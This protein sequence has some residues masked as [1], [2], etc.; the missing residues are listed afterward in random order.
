MP[1]D[2]CSNCVFWYFIKTININQNHSG[3]IC[4]TELINIDSVLN[5]FT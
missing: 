3:S 4:N 5:L 1:D 2:S